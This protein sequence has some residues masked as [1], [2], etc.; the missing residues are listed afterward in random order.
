VNETLCILSDGVDRLIRAG[1][2]GLLWSRGIDSGRV[3]SRALKLF[4]S[5][6]NASVDELLAPEIPEP[7]LF[8]PDTTDAGVGDVL[9][10]LTLSTSGVHL[11]RSVC[12]GIAFHYRSQLLSDDKGVN[13][14]SL[15]LCGGMFEHRTI[16]RIYAHVFNLPVARLRKGAG[17][18]LLPLLKLNDHAV[19]LETLQ[20]FR[21]TPLFEPDHALHIRYT[22]H[23]KRYSSLK[24]DTILYNKG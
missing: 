23:Y 19:F 8:V 9:F 5:P 22:H 12:Q 24:R 6:V 17:Q 18:K 20:N 14:E 7:L 1:P 13:V 3:L 10:G 16:C 21:E 15:H 2:G 4:T 11:L